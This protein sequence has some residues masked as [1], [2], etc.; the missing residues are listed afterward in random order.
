MTESKQEPIKIKE[1]GALMSRGKSAGYITYDDLNKHLPGGLV[2]ADRIEQVINVFTEMGIEVVDPER[3]PTGA[4]AMRKDRLRKEDSALRAD[5]TTL[6]TVIR[7]DD[8]VRMY[9]REMGTVELLTREGEIEIARRIEE[10]RLQIHEAICLCPATFRSI[11]DLGERVI[12]IRDEAI[13][14]DEEMNFRNILD[15]DDKVVNSAAI[16]EYEKRLNNLDDEEDEPEEPEK[17]DPEQLSAAIKARTATP[18]GTPMEETVITKEEQ[19]EEALKHFSAAKEAHDEF[20]TIKKKLEKKADEKLQARLAELLQIMLTELVAIPFSNNQIEALI[21]KFKRAV[22]R[23]RGYEREI[24]D[25]SLAAKM[26]RKAFIDSFVPNIS[27]EKW[28]KLVQEEFA[29]KPWMPAFEEASEKILEQQ[30]RLKRVEQESEMHVT[31]LKEVARKLTMGEAKMRQAKREMIEANLRLV[32]SIAKKYTN[33]G[34][35]FLDLIQEGNIGLMK[36]VDK[37]EWRRGYKFSTYA[38]WW[39]RQAI[40]RSIADQARTIRIPVH[41]IETIN[42]MMRVS[43]QIAQEIGREPTPEELAQHLEMPLDKVK[44][45]LEVAKEPVSLETPI[46]DDED[47]QLGDFVEDENA[48]DPLDGAISASLQLATLEVLEN[49]T[50][51]EEKVLRMRFGIGMNTDH[52]LEEVGKQFGVTR[53]RIRQIEAKAL[54]KLRHP[55]RS[56][57]LK[58]FADSNEDALG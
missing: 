41:M 39:I 43:R 34:L 20:M 21:Q 45:I 22:E 9:L 23:V 18:D 50:S 29:G 46:G 51:R 26:P 53:E 48:E 54:R 38:T 16:A 57:K 36:A 42:K 28:V 14:N 2:S 7:I 3:A 47:S 17:L 24:R 10:G 6:G 49:L 31:E 37:F 25:L 12:R 32:I 27:N 4:Y 44:Q 35:G 30:L 11:M 13:E 19:L 40:T 33:R 15:I 58:T 55:S 52:T 5:T 1:L 8:P 56:H